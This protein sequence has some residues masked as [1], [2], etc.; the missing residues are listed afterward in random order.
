MAEFD[1][2]VVIDVENDH[3]GRSPLPPLDPNWSPLTKLRWHAGLV[4]FRTGIRCRITDDSKLVIDGQEVADHYGI[5]VGG[6]KTGMSYAAAWTYLN[7][8][9]AGARAAI[10][11][12]A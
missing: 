10:L 3:G 7:G 6:S 4:E 5:S 8:V 9:E 11:V 1:P 2:M 12:E